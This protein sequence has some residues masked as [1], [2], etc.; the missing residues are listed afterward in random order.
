MEAEE[1]EGKIFDRKVPA[2]H[3]GKAFSN[4]AWEGGER[5]GVFPCGE[6]EHRR[7]EPGHHHTAYLL[8]QGVV[9]FSRGRFQKFYSI[10]REGTICLS[11]GKI[12]PVG[13]GGSPFLLRPPHL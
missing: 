7:E 9:Y 13:E 5:G 11:L 12:R 4:C 1:D 3:E 6:E 8:H 2:Q 10:D